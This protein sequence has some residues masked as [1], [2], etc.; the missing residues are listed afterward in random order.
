LINTGCG[1]EISIRE[2]AY[3]IKNTVG[4]EGDVDFDTL[5]PDGTPQKL[6]DVSGTQ[7]LGW[8]QKIS[9]KERPIQT[10][11]WYLQNGI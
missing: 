4:F 1:E 2:L 10:Y 7:A 8:S 6:L 11:D 5:K 9:L 3:L